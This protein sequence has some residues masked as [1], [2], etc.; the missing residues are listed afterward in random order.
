MKF[1]DFV[2][3]NNL[4]ERVSNVGRNLGKSDYI[5][6]VREIEKKLQ[7]TTSISKQIE[8]LSEMVIL[9]GDLVL[10]RR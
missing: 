8:Y 2:E 7:R 6:V 3:T 1:K 10:Y 4:D 9:V 5:K